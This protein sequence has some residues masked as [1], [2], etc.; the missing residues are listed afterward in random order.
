GAG[1]RQQPARGDRAGSGR[2]LLHGSP[3]QSQK[4]RHA[5]MCRLTL[6]PK[7]SNVQL[8]PKLFL[9][10]NEVTFSMPPMSVK[11]FNGCRIRL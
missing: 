10:S 5:L 6:R 7:L 3:P 9:L 1:G 2:R 11:S 4:T 8:R